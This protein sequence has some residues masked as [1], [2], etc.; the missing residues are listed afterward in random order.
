MVMKLQINFSYGLSQRR[1]SAE[2]LATL[3][4]SIRRASF[5]CPYNLLLV[6]EWKASHR[7]TESRQQYYTAHDR[8]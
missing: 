5:N 8:E 1:V 7:P 4:G 6:I 3:D 2:E